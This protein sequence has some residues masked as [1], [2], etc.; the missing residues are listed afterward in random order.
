MTDLVTCDNDK[1]HSSSAPHSARKSQEIWLIRHGETEWTLSGAHTGKT[2]IP[3]TDAG[4][5]K[6]MAVGRFLGGRRFDLVLSSPL[7]R[8]LETCR[9]AGY[10]DVAETDARLCEWDYGDYEGRTTPDIRKSRPGWFLWTAGVPN[11]EAISDVATRADEVL[12]RASAIN[13]SGAP[14]VAMFAHGHILRILAARWL[15]LAPDCG[16][17]LSLG[18]GTVSVLGYEREVRVITRWNVEPGA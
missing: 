8:A 16:R 9:L 3:L 13:G 17:L 2:D 18:T 5:E 12:E 11:G 6:A 15:G 1:Q 4:R 10:G 7:G 14:S